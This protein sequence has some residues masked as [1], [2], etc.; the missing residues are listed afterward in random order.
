M[1]HILEWLSSSG[2]VPTSET[3]CV[4]RAIRVHPRSEARRPR[5]FAV[6]WLPCAAQ[7]WGF[8]MEGKRPLLVIPSASEESLGERLIWQE[9][10]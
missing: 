1:S 5:S 3:P 4:F 6:V 10:T 2:P 8:L 7:G 9:A